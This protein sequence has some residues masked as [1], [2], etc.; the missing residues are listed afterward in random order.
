MTISLT[1]IDFLSKHL[2]KS[3]PNFPYLM[4]DWF[5]ILMPTIG[6]LDQIR[7]M[8][9][10]KNCEIFSMNSALVLISANILKIIFWFFEP[11][12]TSL[13][14]QSI[15]LLN[16]ALFHTYLHYY[17]KDSIENNNNKL[18]YQLKHSFLTKIK[19]PSITNLKNI[20]HIGESKSFIDFFFQILIYF[21]IF[22]FIYIFGCI[23]INIHFTV[24][25]TSIIANIIDSLVSIPQFKLI[26]LQK[27]IK[28]TSIVLIFQYLF[29][30]LFKLFIFYISKSPWP[31]FFGGF[32]QLSIDSLIMIFFFYLKKKQKI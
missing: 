27:N 20:F 22:I 2:L 31:F 4:I 19:I 12:A 32:L 13:F 28:N 14:G 16:V 8:I 21:L 6:Y 17:Y 5:I 23:I 26:V 30:D 1:S 9:L 7:M 10:T 24:Q 3:I 11:F 18:S 25:V 15:A 29:G